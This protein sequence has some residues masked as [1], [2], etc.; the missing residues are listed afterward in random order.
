MEE[1]TV[2]CTTLGIIL[3]V[4]KLIKFSADF[5][6]KEFAIITLVASSFGIEFTDWFR[7]LSFFFL[8]CIGTFAGRLGGV[9]V[10]FIPKAGIIFAG[11]ISTWFVTND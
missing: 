5:W 1:A 7:V 6:M 2:V 11:M 3:Y 4:A 9:F 8:S 10:D